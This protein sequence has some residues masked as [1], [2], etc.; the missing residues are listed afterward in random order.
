MTPSD[1]AAI[2]GELAIRRID[3]PDYRPRSEVRAVA[4]FTLGVLGGK[5]ARQRLTLPACRR[6][7]GL[8]KNRVFRIGV[9]HA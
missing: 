2:Y 6:T 9:R 8:L 1:R 7:V 5:E 3:I 4:A